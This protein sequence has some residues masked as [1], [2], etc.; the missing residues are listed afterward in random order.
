MRRRSW[1]A[2]TLSLSLLMS[3]VLSIGIGSVADAGT[4]SAVAG[5]KPSWA[6]SGSRVRHADPSQIIGFRLYLGWRGGNAAAALAR[7]VSNPR[8]SSY[9][10]YLT[11]VQFRQ[12][13]A[14]TAAAVAAV[15]KFLRDNGFKV[16]YTPGNNHFVAAEGTVTQIDNSF[17]TQL[18]IYKVAGLQLR[19]PSTNLSVPSSIAGLLSGAIGIDQSYDFAHANIRVDKGEPPP[20]GFRNAPAPS[21]YWAEKVSPYAYP[22]GFMEV[23]K[24]STA[25]WLS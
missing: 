21:H 19:S 6:S 23:F 10:K 3:S 14:P 15:Q 22:A 8:S 9:G 1:L 16:N 18:N 4:R 11:S 17:A 2:T 25:P 12:Q 13:F 7:A 20:A 5:T 24:P